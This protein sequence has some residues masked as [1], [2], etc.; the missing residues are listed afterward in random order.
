MWGYLRDVEGYFGYL[1]GLSVKFSWLGIVASGIKKLSENKAFLF[2]KYPLFLGLNKWMWYSI[3]FSHSV[4]L[5]SPPK[6][7]F[8]KGFLRFS[9]GE[10][11][12]N[13]HV[14]KVEKS[15][16]IFIFITY[17]IINNFQTIHKINQTI[18]HTS[19]LHAK[20]LT[21]IPTFYHAFAFFISSIIPFI[22][23]SIRQSIPTIAPHSPQK[24]KLF[25]HFLPK[26]HIFS[27][28]NHDFS[29]P[30]TISHNSIQF[31]QYWHNN[32]NN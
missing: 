30:C 23:F 10:N 31:K 25:P 27:I 8:F 16:Q 11:E 4:I 15:P 19:P 32:N 24:S 22:P 2:V 14:Y 29:I 13:E 26:N 9:F 6:H 20:Q 12:K 7:W 5:K 18:P 17:T 1:W 3:F 21:T 28:K